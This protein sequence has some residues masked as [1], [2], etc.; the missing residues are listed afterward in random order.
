[1]H[2]RGRGYGKAGD[3]CKRWKWRV[4]NRRWT[5]QDGLWSRRTLGRLKPVSSEKGKR[6]QARYWRLRR[7]QG[8]RLAVVFEA[9][10]DKE[11]ISLEDLLGLGYAMSE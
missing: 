9:R 1:M 8:L 5:K 3:E 11:G 10:L 4:H 6:A 2:R 7:R